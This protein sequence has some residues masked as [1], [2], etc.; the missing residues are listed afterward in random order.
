M[1]INPTKIKWIIFLC[2]WWSIIDSTVYNEP[3][4]A[5]F[6]RGLRNDCRV[7]VTIS[8]S[9][10]NIIMPNEWQSRM[11]PVSSEIVIENTYWRL[12]NRLDYGSQDRNESSQSILHSWTLS[13]RLYGVWYYTIVSAASRF[14]RPPL[15]SVW[16]RVRV[17]LGLTIQIWK[18]SIHTRAL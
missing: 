10:V 15:F 12:C 9:C 18:W 1:H 4:I 6:S 2:V 5:Y 16:V 17:R 14:P 3:K 13:L 7:F 11:V 8:L